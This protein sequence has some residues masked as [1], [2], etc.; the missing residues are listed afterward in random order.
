MKVSIITPVYNDPRIERALRSVSKQRCSHDIESII[1]DGGSSDETLD[2]LQRYKE[3]TSLIISEPDLGLYD[4]MNKGIGY[5]TGDVIGVLNADDCY[6][7]EYVVRDVMKT[8]L[9]DPELDSCYGDL[10]YLDDG[11]NIIRYWKS[12]AQRIFKWYFGWR[13][14]HPSFFVRRQVYERY[15]NFDLAFPIASDYE[16][17]MRFLLK[18]TISS[19]HINRVL[20]CMAPGGKSNGSIRNI[21][22]ANREVRCA[23]G[24]N[25]LRGG[26]MVPIFKPFS[27]LL[28]I[29]RRP[30]ADDLNRVPSWKW[31]Q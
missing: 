29:V 17:Q 25:Q 14:P 13:P 19:R 9:E 21:I 24:H 28:Q 2:V 20:V 30:S 7:D 23:W 15:G 8:F 5:A 27:S 18:H 12:N 3:Q 6:V 1:I 31:S 26:M 4:G 11:G 10:I 22:D 16:L